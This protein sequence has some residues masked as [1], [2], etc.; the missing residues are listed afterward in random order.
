VRQRGRR[1]LIIVQNLPVP[2]DR[3]VW[4]ECQALVGA[5][6]RVSVV[7]PKG[8]GDPSYQLLEGVHLHKYE[9]PPPTTGVASFA[10]EFASCWA[11]TARLV[12]R[13]ARREGFD[14]IQTCNPPDTYFALAWPFK[15]LGRP[16]VF[17]QHDLCP[18]VYLSRF[19]RPSPVLWRGLRVLEWLTYRTADHV[20][21][22]NDSYRDVA[23]GRGGKRPDQVT[24]VRTGPDPDRL[25]PAPPSPAL[26]RGRRFLCCYLGVMGP[27]DGVDL[28]VRAA[29]V[30]VHQ[31]GRTDCHFALIGNGDCY[32]DLRALV[33]ELG[34]EDFVTMPG[35]APDEVVF[36][37]FSTA[38]VGLS[39]DPPGPLND[40][41][42]MNKTMEYMAFELP[43]VAFDLKETRVSAGDAGVYVPGRDVTAFARAISDLLDDPDRRARMG[44][45]GRRRVEEALAWRHQVGAYVAVY[46]RLLGNVRRPGP[47]TG[48]GVRTVSSP[49][50]GGP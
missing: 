24:V 10:Y 23:T 38:D 42:T 50:P 43:V 36:D 9:P 33:G 31:L 45:F 27:Q 49:A 17:D 19:D 39:P 15:L 18:E 5:G 14:V 25:R 6:Y 30:L 8:P 1:V 12:L 35:R 28:A 41:S 16:F 20:I 44:A 46:D 48:D 34:L 21:A 7:C 3:R 40:V 37:Y 26:R 11:K 22:T 4:L 29:D 2:T 32:D 47:S 13:A